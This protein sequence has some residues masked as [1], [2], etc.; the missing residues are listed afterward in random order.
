MNENQFKKHVTSVLDKAMKQLVHTGYDE[1]KNKKKSENYEVCLLNKR[2]KKLKAPW[3][4]ES[5]FDIPNDIV[6]DA[7]TYLTE[8]IRIEKKSRKPWKG[9]IRVVERRK[10]SLY[11]NETYIL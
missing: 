11:L 2:M 9:K 5:R 1:K 4:G 7:N 6:W 8:K 3:K 10:L